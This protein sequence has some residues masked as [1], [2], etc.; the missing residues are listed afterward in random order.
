LFRFLDVEDY[1]CPAYDLD[2]I[3]QEATVRGA[4]VRKMVDRLSICEVEEDKRIV[5]Q[6]IIYG[7]RALDG[8]EI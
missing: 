8:R 5:Q 1:S 3:K 6:S 2:D 7:L 4:F